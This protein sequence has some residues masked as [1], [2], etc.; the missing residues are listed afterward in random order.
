MRD[1]ASNRYLP[2]PGAL[3]LAIAGMA[4]MTHAH[5]APQSS[6]PGKSH[7]HEVRLEEIVVTAT[8]LRST[9]DALSEPVEILAGERLDEDKAATLGETVAGL[10][11]VQSSYF[12]P[13]V[14]RPIIRGLDGPRVGVLANGLGSQDV[15]TVSQDHSLAIEPFL[16]D[17]IEVLKGP[18]TLLYGSGAIGGVVNVVDGRIPE[19]APDRSFSGRSELRHDAVSDGFTGMLRADTGNDRFAIHFDGLKRDNEDYEIPDGTLA[20]SF[21]ET[22][23]G[24]FGGSLLGDWGFLGVSV[25]RFLDTYG[26][27][28]EPGNPAEGE[29]GVFLDI[30]Q[31]RTEFKGG[32]TRSFGVFTGARFAISSGDYRHIEFEGEEIGTT[33]VNDSTEGR[34][35]LTH[36]PVGNWTGAFGVQFSDREFEAIGEEA[37]V[38]K[39]QT[40]LL[41]IFVV[42]QAKWGRLQLDLGARIE[43][44]ESSPEDQPSRDFD[45]LS[46]S[47]GAIWRFDESLHLSFNLDRAD[48]APAE[49]ELFAN[50]PHVATASFEIGDPDLS[51]E[52]A[53]QAEIGLH[54]HGDVI[55]AKASI[56]Y[57]RF[58]NFI[59]LVDTGETEDDLPVRQ[60]T[61]NDARF[62]G[63]EGEVLWHISDGASGAFDVRVFGDTVRATLADDSGNVPRIVPARV[64]ADLRW[65]ADNWR[66]SVGAVRHAEQDDVA[67]NETPTDG[68]TLVDAHVAYHVDGPSLAW[69]I[70]ADATNL[71]D[72]DARVHTSFLKDRV[73]LPGRAFSL[74]FRAYF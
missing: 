8:P 23:T 27:P 53:N 70:F 29:G 74:G 20:N 46:L 30:E 14:G 26:N 17:Q 31:D 35:E 69:E 41:G 24:A 2:S 43:T 58:D 42:E 7:E 54:F 63:F 10:P 50:G 6:G 44:V 28:G 66:A 47:A 61:Q 37:F 38:P 5:A 68:Y 18:A 32:Y 1:G 3:A 55:E 49:E 45:P 40:D 12:G 4:G 48:R 19:H 36:A 65:R 62:R 16:A 60:W 33:F 11:G 51:E 59:F 57:N 64:G 21:I 39:T 15:S 67:V 56:Y 13:G 34:L 9:S 73:P 52:T 22:R 71:T 25:S 72:Q